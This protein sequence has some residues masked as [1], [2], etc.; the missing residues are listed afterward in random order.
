MVKTRS[1]K[2]KQNLTISGIKDVP[3]GCTTCRHH[4]ITTKNP[5]WHGKQFGTSYT[6]IKLNHHI[7]SLLIRLKEKQ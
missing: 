5:K 3:L 1:N 2:I 7:H 6:V 4:Y